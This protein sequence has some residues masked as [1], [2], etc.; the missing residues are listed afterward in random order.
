MEDT[1][2]SQTV[3]NQTVSNG[4]TGNTASISSAMASMTETEPKKAEPV[5]GN[6]NGTETS[7]KDT[8]S[9]T[10]PTWTSQLPDTIK[11]NEDLMKQL[12][13]FEKIGDLA[14]SYAELENKLGKSIVIPGKDATAE[15]TKAFYQKLGMPKEAKGY[16]LEG[17]NIDD[18]KNIAYAANLTQAQ[19]KAVFEL[20]GNY[21]KQ[22]AANNQANAERQ[23]R[24]TDEMLHKEYG[25]KYAEK[26]ALLQRGVQ[27]Y[28]GKE[29]G[30][31]LQSAG[32]FYNPQ[33]VRL[34]IQ[35]GEQ[36]AESGTST[37]GAGGGKNTYKPTNEGGSFTF[38]EL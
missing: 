10:Y 34:F 24:E 37:V 18:F 17:E 5:N 16:E 26:I 8:V 23:M 36:S 25:N 12:E 1:K 21:G 13:K 33:I 32:I 22:I 20:M 29:L 3:N 9:K 15:E 19:A 14:N 4:D 35:L 27:N 30:Q 38:K 11:G 28:G 6:A 7:Q 31:L 2:D